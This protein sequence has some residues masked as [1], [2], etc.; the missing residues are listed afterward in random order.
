MRSTFVPNFL[1]EKSSSGYPPGE[2]GY[3]ERRDKKDRS[4][5]YSQIINERSKRINEKSLERIEDSPENTAYAEKYRAQKHYSCQ[6]Y[7]FA[8][9][10]P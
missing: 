1:M 6:G 8:Q 2:T 9:L 10:F 4:Q 5:D 3:P 7:Y